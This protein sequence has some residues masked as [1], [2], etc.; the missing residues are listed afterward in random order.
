MNFK[1]IDDVE[2][3]ATERNSIESNPIE[4]KQFKIRVAVAGLLGISAPWFIGPANAGPGFGVDAN[5]GTHNPTYY[6][7]SPAGT[8]TDWKGVAHA[9]G[10]ALRKFHDCLPMPGSTPANPCTNAWGDTPLNGY[11]P[12]A[13]KDTSSYTGSDYYE[14]GIVEYYPEDAQ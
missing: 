11:I 10:T 9:S 14:I 2:G 12:V 6:A 8:W 13:T 1:K 3:S 7:N 5:G 4:F